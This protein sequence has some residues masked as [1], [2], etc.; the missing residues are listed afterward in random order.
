MCENRIWGDGFFCL[1]VATD[2]EGW[3]GGGLERRE[4]T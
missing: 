4:G 2:C 1:G 3:R